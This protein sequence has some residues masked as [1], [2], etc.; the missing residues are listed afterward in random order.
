MTTPARRIQPRLR[1]I[2]KVFIPENQTLAVG[3]AE[4]L[5]PF[6]QFDKG[7]RGYTNITALAH[8]VVYGDYYRIVQAFADKIISGQNRFRN[9]GAGLFP[10]AF[11]N[12]DSILY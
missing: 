2:G 9:P 3:T 1:L 8:S 11:Q 5:F 12:L 10:L 7:L 4:Y 6:L